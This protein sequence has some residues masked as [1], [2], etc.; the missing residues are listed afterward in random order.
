MDDDLLSDFSDVGN[1]ASTDEYQKWCEE[2]R[3]PN[4]Y[5]PLEFWSTQRQK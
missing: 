3:Q 2:G 5:R 4:V 1:D